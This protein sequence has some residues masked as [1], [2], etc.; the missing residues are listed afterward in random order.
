MASASHRGAPSSSSSS[1]SSPSSLAAAAAASRLYRWFKLAAATGLR[2]LRPWRDFA[3]NLSLPSAQAGWPALEQRVAANLWFWRSNYAALA[4]AL[5]A[6][7]LVTRPRLLLVAAATAALAAQ[8]LA[9]SPSP[10]RV[11]PLDVRRGKCT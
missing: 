11:P 5:S 2:E 4:L 1:A 8:L 3:S 7:A 6:Y 10:L 9:L